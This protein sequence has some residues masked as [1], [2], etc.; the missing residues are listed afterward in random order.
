MGASASAT[1]GLA[2][3]TGGK[4]EVKF[5]GRFEATAR[6]S[7]GTITKGNGGFKSAVGKLHRVGEEVH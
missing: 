7:S 2:Q 3:F 4:G 1:E 6:S 5:S